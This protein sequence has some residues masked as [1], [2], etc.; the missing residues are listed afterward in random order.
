[1]NALFELGIMLIQ[2]LQTMS[3]ALDGPMKVISFMG[4]T[5]F[6]LIL[7]PLIYW[8][9]SKRLGI[10]ILLILV[11]TDF[12]GIFFKQL[13]HQPRPYWVSDQVQLLSTDKTYG[14]PSTHASDSLAV[15]GYLAYQMRRGG[16]WIAI[17]VL[18]FLIGLSRLYLGVHFPHDVLFG[19][20]VGAV[21]LLLFITAEQRLTP[22]LQ[23]QSA[24]TVIGLGFGVSMVI[25][26]LGLLS[27]AIISGSPDPA[28]W[29]S[30]AVH[31]RSPAG[32]FTLGGGLFGS[33]TGFVLM[34]Q[35]ARFRTDGTWMQRAGR[36]LLGII[37]V[38]LC[39]QG[40]SI[41][42]DF[43]AVDET[44]LGYILRYI[45]YAVTTFWAIFGAPW[46]FLRVKLAEE[47]VGD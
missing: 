9:V 18:V 11:S 14:I 35:Y 34:Q 20:I 38:F 7:I 1:M 25:V 47:E 12:M 26:L 10:R 41:L 39:W 8:T 2:F 37:G 33:V 27:G 15:W 42:F 43:I 13:L 45:R 24:G 23:T 28:D 21:V 17:T 16:F 44:A 22:W 6:Y 30:F 36:F 29:A 46:V 31:S 32:F 19:W 3:P 5:E 40:L 4:T